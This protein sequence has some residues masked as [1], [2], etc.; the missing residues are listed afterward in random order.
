MLKPGILPEGTPEMKRQRRV[1]RTNLTFAFAQLRAEMLEN[2]AGKARRLPETM[3][4]L[5]F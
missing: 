2:D 3:E 1:L 5:N 4:N